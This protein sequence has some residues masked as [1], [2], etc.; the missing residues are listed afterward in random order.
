MQ[1][2]HKDTVNKQTEVNEL[3]AK[4]VLSERE[5]KEKQRTKEVEKEKAKAIAD[6]EARYEDKGV[7][8]TKQ[9]KKEKAYKSL[10]NGLK[11]L[12]D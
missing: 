1:G 3:F 10:L 11:G 4:A 7:K 9:I 6:V 8:S 2:F 12:A 5:V